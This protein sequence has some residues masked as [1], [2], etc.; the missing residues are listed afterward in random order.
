MPDETIEAHYNAHDAAQRYYPLWE[1]LGLNR[2]DP[3]APGPAFSVIMPPPNVTGALHMGHALN[4]TLQDV[5]VRYKRMDGYNVVWIPGLDHAS[6]AVHWVIERELIKEGTDRTRI[7]REAF[8]AR[9]QAFKEASQTRITSQQ[10]Q[11][12]I[13]CDWDRLAFTLDAPRQKS[14]TEAF[15]RLY[16]DGLIYR[17]ERL[18]NWDPISQTTVSDLEVEHQENVKGELYSFAYPLS[19]G[20]GE[21]V[22]ATT[23][24][25]TLFGDSAIAVHPK[26]PRYMHLI[27]KTVRHPLMDRHLPIVAD[28]IL[29]DPAVWHRRGQNYPSPRLQRLRSGQTPHTQ[30]P[31][32]ARKRW[33]ACSSL[34]QLCGSERAQGAPGGQR[35]AFGFGP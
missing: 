16:E 11:L 24:P 17:A 35:K 15:V 30:K 23:R 4:N 10:R 19:E 7:G 21:L 14:V 9:A 32:R 22:V 18:V 26:D 8:L 34:R 25:E 31:Q 5:L 12:G 1:A 6:I 2:G 27:G 28:A 3:N 33:H 13:S 20:E 29:V